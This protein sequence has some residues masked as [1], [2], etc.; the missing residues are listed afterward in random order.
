MN[1]YI[2]LDGDDVQESVLVSL[3]DAVKIAQVELDEKSQVVEIILHDELS[4]DMLP[5]VDYFIVN[6]KGDYEDYEYYQ[7]EVLMANPFSQSTIDDIVED[8]L[9]KTLLEVE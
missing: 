7:I 8:F 4:D 5:E 2:P 9:F 1:L 3:E 6:K